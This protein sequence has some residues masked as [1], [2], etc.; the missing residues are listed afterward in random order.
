MVSS[1]RGSPMSTGWRAI[2]ASA[3]TQGTIQLFDG[4]SGGSLQGV[5]LIAVDGGNALV[6]ISGE[7]ITGISLAG[8]TFDAGDNTAVLTALQLQ[9]L[10]DA[11]DR[12]DVVLLYSLQNSKFKQQ[13]S[14]T[15]NPLF[16]DRRDLLH[17]VNLTATYEALRWLTVTPICTSGLRNGH[18]SRNV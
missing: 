2:A 5:K 12:I 8:N 1:S 6:S 15:V 10:W 11:T 9:T 16:Q 3:G 4:F 18:R 7:A 14:G 17:E 13:P